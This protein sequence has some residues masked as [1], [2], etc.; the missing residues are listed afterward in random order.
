[1]KQVLNADPHSKIVLQGHDPVTFHTIG[2]AIKGN[3]AISAEHCGYRYLF[4]SENNKS[5]FEERVEEYLPAFGGFC[6]YGVSLG[7]LFPVEINTWEIIDGRLVLQYS[8]DV[9]K[10]F[11]EQ[12]NENIRKA[13]ENWPNLKADSIK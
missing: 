6:A 2:K 10:K 1:M 5:A 9:K 12:K 7:V 8:Q 4:S 13:N 11:D 3:P